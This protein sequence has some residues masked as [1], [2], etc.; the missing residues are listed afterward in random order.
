[1]DNVALEYILKAILLLFVILAAGLLL[2]RLGIL[3]IEAFQGF[4]P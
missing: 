4:N 1:M 2:S 3:N